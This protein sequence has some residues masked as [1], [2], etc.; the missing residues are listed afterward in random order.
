MISF[1]PL[2]CKDESD[3]GSVCSSGNH[4]NKNFTFQ[5]YY[6]NCIPLYAVCDYHRD[7]PGKFHEDEQ[8]QICQQRLLNTTQLS[9]RNN[10]NPNVS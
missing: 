2:D 1:I 3:E 7:C 4:C 9:N 6:G 8:K 10:V 5:C